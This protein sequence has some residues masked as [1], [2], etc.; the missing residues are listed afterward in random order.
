MPTRVPLR[1]KDAKAILTDLKSKFQLDEGIFGS[2]PLVEKTQLRNGELI[3]INGKPV[4]LK[5]QSQLIPTLKFDYLVGKLARLVVDMGAVPHICNGADVMARGVRSI[6]GE[7]M[8]GALVAIVDETH[9]KQIAIAEALADSASIREMKSGKAASNL[10]FV[11]DEAWDA[12][13]SNG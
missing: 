6:E 3:L 12:M 11:G 1:G 9:R 13:K 4:L 7:F 2:K 10:H 8:K 5:R